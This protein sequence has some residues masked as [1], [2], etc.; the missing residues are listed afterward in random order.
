MPIHWFFR[1]LSAGLKHRHFLPRSRFMRHNQVTSH[2]SYWSVG[3][4]ELWES[5]RLRPFL[6][7]STP[8]FEAFSFEASL[9]KMQ[10][11]ELGSM[12]KVTASPVPYTEVKSPPT[13]IHCPLVYTPKNSISLFLATV[14]PWELVLICSLTPTCKSC[15]ESLLFHSAGIFWSSAHM[16][17][18]T[19][20]LCRA[21]PRQRWAFVVCL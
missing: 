15:A 11:A 13:P 3:R 20:T 8:F 10:T 5:L 12:F 17:C 16:S 7:L 2:P 19:N 18:S 1:P 6:Q 14:L 9:S 21:P 4:S